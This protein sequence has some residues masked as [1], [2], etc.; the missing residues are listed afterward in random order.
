MDIKDE[1]VLNGMHWYAAENIEYNTI[2]EFQT[3]DSKDLGYYIVLWTGNAY[4][5]QEKYTCHT[6]DSQVIISEGELVCPVKFMTP[7]RK[8]SCWRHKPDE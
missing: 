4:T 5:L 3:S 8:T 7:M 1:L 2:G 6:F